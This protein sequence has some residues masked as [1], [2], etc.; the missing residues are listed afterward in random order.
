MLIVYEL[1]ADDLLTSHLKPVPGRCPRASKSS[2]WCMCPGYEPLVLERKAKVFMSSN[3]P[4]Y[5]SVGCSA[6]AF[7]PG[8]RL[9]SVWE[10]STYVGGETFLSTVIVKGCRRG[11][12]RVWSVLGFSQSIS[13]IWTWPQR[14]TGHKISRVGFGPA[15][16]VRT[17]LVD[18]KSESP[19][20]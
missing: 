5:V 19:F 16:G 17:W 1:R 9:L 12:K 14:T 18:A 13:T 11:R 15:Y 8:C 7:C 3:K 10:S 6:C 20:D 2:L 4:Q